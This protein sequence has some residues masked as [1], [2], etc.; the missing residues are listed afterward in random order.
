MTSCEALWTLPGDR[1][2]VGNHRA[3]SYMHNHWLIHQPWHPVIFI[4][5]YSTDYSNCNT[6]NNWMQA[7]GNADLM[8]KS[9]EQ[10]KC[11]TAWYNWLWGKSL[12][13]NWL[14]VN[15][16]Y[17]WKL[18]CKIQ[19]FH[20][21]HWIYLNTWGSVHLAYGKTQTQSGTPK[22]SWEFAVCVCVPVCPASYT[23]THTVNHLVLIRLDLESLSLLSCL[24]AYAR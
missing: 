12:W 13:L 6:A 21:G 16:A 4:K 23:H 15:T 20:D 5:V 7:F 1:S 3:I 8:F 24:A 17:I 19:N 10:S 18:E 14:Y 11:M 9:N 2:Q 22:L